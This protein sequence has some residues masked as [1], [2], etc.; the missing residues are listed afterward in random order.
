MPYRFFV[1]PMLQNFTFTTGEKCC[2]AGACSNNSKSFAPV[3]QVSCCE[4]VYDSLS[5]GKEVL[6]NLEFAKKPNSEKNRKFTS[7]I[8]RGGHRIGRS[9]FLSRRPFA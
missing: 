4:C 6:R 3:A 2:L 7:P 9:V 8:P 1:Q 5:M